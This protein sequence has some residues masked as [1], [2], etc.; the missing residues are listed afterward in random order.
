MQD[1]ITSCCSSGNLNVKEKQN[2]KP[3]MTKKNWEVFP[4]RNR[5]YCDGRIMMSRSNCVFA[6]TVILIVGTTGLFFAI[7]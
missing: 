3:V 7:E 5:F 6:I 1:P 4:G 2:Y